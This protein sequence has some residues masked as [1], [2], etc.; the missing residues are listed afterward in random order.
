MNDP[1]NW[2]GSD[3]KQVALQPGSALYDKLCNEVNGHCHY[4]TVVVLDSDLAYHA[5]ECD[6]DSLRVVLVYP[7]IYYEYIRPP[8]RSPNFAGVTC[9][10][11]SSW[12]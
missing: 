8:L 12:C 3:P 1:C 11:N 10:R 7:G 4:P 2:E 9:T 5:D 6:V